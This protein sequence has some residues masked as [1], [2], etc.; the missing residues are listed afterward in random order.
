MRSLT[1]NEIL[2]DLERFPNTRYLAV[3]YDALESPYVALRASSRVVTQLAQQP[4]VNAFRRVLLDPVRGL[5]L[6]MSPNVLH[7]VLAEDVNIV[8]DVT[9]MSLGINSKPM[10]ATRWRRQG[11]PEGTGIE[12]DKCYYVGDKTLQLLGLNTQER[13]DFFD[14]H[15]P[16]LVVEVT[17]SHFYEQKINFYRDHG[18]PEYWQMRGGEEAPSQ[19][20]F[21]GLQDRSEPLSLS[22][23]L[24]LPGFTP[25]A[26]QHCLEVRRRVAPLKYARAIC[27]VLDDYGVIHPTRENSINGGS[28][29]SG[30][31]Y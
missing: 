28:P 19:V 30:L 4:V 24:A 11:D 25:V 18:V 10:G 31:Q 17:V 3:H 20:S 9:A 8:V 21:L 5:V 1:L 12:P 22:A 23:S 26:L 2:A 16:D 29:T 15:P 7:E 14:M 6:L 13:Q 27:D